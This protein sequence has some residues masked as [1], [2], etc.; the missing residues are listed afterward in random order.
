MT[1]IFVA[2]TAASPLLGLTVF[3]LNEV[4]TASTQMIINPILTGTIGAAILFA[5]FTLLELDRVYKFKTFALTD[6]IAPS[7]ALHTAKMGALFAVSLVTGLIVLLAYFPTTASSMGAFFDMELYVKSYLIFMVPSMW[8][9]SLFAAIFYQVFRRVDLSFVGVL[10]CA[11]LCLNP[12]IFEDFILRWII[13]N[14][15]VFSD[16]FG[17]DKPLRMGIYGRVFWL[18]FLVGAWFISLMFTRKYEKGAFGSFLCNIKKFY[19]PLVGIALIVL[20]VNHYQSQPFFNSA[21]IEVDWDALYD[22][23]ERLNVTSVNA[24]I[25]PDFNRGRMNGR[26]T[27]IINGNASEEKR[28]LIINSG[29]TVYSMTLDGEPIEFTDLNN[30][31]FVVKHIEFEI[32][33]GGEMELVVEYGGHPMLWGI[34]SM[35]LGGAEISPRNVEL[36]NHALIPSLGLH[37][38]E[39][40]VTIILPEDH[41]LIALEGTVT[42]GS[43]NGDATRTWT[44]TNSR[45]SINIYASD[46][47]RR[48]IEVNDITVEFYHHARFTELLEKNSIDEVLLDVFNFCTERF[49]PLIYLKDNRLRLIQTS[50]F[51]FGGSAGAGTSNMGETAFSIYSLSDPW[52][53]ASGRE[54]LAHEIIH[55]WWG[56]NRMIWECDESPEW[57]AEGLTVY[58]TYRLYKEKYGEEYG[59]IH[60]VDEWQRAVD[61]MNRNFFRRNPEYLEIMSENFAARL[62][63]QERQVMQYS[64]M[65]LKIRRA[66]ELVGGEE[67]FDEILAY[68]S[69][70]NNFDILTYQEFLDAIGLTRED[71]RLD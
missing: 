47:V 14:L 29:Y 67:K 64:L 7:V 54:I 1:W 49:G 8:I 63:V 15:P 51:N 61:S 37:D 58:S 5:L 20:S 65:P 30:D 26:I 60:Y 40:E 62:R 17:N 3:Q 28:R 66:E 41:T 53:G 38:T 13:P 34:S 36:W 11:L 23:G 16:A 56:L 22:I 33:I 55:Q 59:R 69:S 31:I 57:S 24:K 6:A 71:L 9:G 25:T 39:T 43:D 44:I 18:M 48:V 32:P 10:A 12:P 45:D 19:L 35:M 2:L 50:A 4:Q 52:K 21:S 68:L 27:Y 42:G 46:Y 70:T